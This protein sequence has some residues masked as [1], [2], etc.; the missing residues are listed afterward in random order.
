MIFDTHAHYHY[1]AFD[2][3]RDNL[4]AVLPENGILR[5]VNASS[6]VSSN[7]TTLQ[8]AEQWP[9]VYAA[10]GVHPS[11]TAEL[12]EENF[13]R[14]KELTD[15]P[16]CVA[17][18][19]I[20][21]DYYYDEPSRDL[22]KKWF[23]AQ[24]QLAKEKGKPVIIH[25]RDAAQDTYDLMKAEHAGDCGGVVH[26]FSYSKE[27]ARLY[28]RMGFYIGVGGVVTFKNAR[29]LKEVVED[30]PLEYI[31]LETDCPYLAPVPFRG[32]RNS[33]LNLPFVVEQIAQIKGITVQEVEEIIWRNALRLYRFSDIG[34]DS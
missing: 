31:V 18:G 33:S 26:C 12:A 1:E 5:I 16:K 10:F 13:K 8:L 30:I 19:E 9:F 24:I 3:D 6:S 23:A 17:V 29:V 14:I 2:G 32:K 20:G 4:L 21:L 7:E 22:Q 25:S 27:M 34:I 15:H 11:N 28:V